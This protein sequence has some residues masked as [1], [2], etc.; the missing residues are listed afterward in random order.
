MGIGGD[1]MFKDHFGAGFQYSFQP[2]KQDYG[3]LQYRQSFIDVDGIYAP[4]SKKR[5]LVQVLGGVG[6]ARTSFSFTQSAC[7]GSAVCTTQ[8]QA[9]GTANH[10]A[11]HGGLALQYFVWNH[12]FI[13]PQFDYHYVPNLTNQFGGNSVP[14]A[15]I[16]IGYGSARE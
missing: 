16:S 15:M 11:I 12:I 13:K 5:W 10:F 9:V 7:V 3:P 8:S 4:I 2:T 14:G 6:A 1:I